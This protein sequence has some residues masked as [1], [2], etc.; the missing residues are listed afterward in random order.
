MILKPLKVHSPDGKTFYEGDGTE[1]TTTPSSAQSGEL[2]NALRRI[3]KI[4]YGATIDEARSVSKIQRDAADLLEQQAARIAELEA[5]SAT[6]KREAQIHAQEAGTANAT[7]GEIYQVVTGSTGEPG[8]WHGA[9]PVRARIAALE[10]AAKATGQAVLSEEHIAQIAHYCETEA[11][12]CL[13]TNMWQCAHM[14]VEE[15]LRAL[16]EPYLHFQIAEVCEDADG[17]KHIEAV[18]EDLDDLPKG[19][20]LYAAP[21]AALENG[22]GRDAEE[23]SLR[24]KYEDACI[25]ANKNARDAERYRWLRILDPDF[26]NVNR[27]SEMARFYGE[28]LD[29]AIDAALSQMQEPGGEG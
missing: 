29:A 6:L 10:S 20:K 2:I 17:F 3:A 25:E 14:A 19:M 5:L 11:H 21:T 4:S 7:I 23:L 28:T 13:G 8:N 26:G 9:E 24:A 18:I 15:T 22:D 27:M 16:S 1:T 12:A